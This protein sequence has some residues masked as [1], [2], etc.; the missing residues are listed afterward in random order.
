LPG[1]EEPIWEGE[2]RHLEV[3]VPSS[4][5][6]RAAALGLSALALLGSAGC[7]AGEAD[8][9]LV[10]SHV[11]TFEGDDVDVK[12][13]HEIGDAI[14]DDSDYGATLHEVWKCAVDR[15]DACYVVDDELES[16]IVRGIRCASVGPRCPRGS[17]RAGRGETVFLGPVVDPDLV[18]ETARG[19]NP[20]QAT[21]R[22]DVFYQAPEG[23]NER[24]GY[25][26]VRVPPVDDPVKRAAERVEANGWGEPRYSFT[27]AAAR[28]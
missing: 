14:T 2:K 1:Q 15:R 22:V 24:C 18:F 19:N 10:A 9:G 3:Q 8:S 17:R 7:G 6:S 20:A 4:A 11:R 27:Y 16:G 26:S 12:S 25:L 23:A 28:P 21:I 5:R 13:C